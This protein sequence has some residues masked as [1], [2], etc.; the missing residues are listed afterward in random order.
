MQPRRIA[1]LLAVVAAVGLS[2]CTITFF[3][4]PSVD[5]PRP[6]PAASAVI[7]RFESFSSSYWVGSRVSFRIRTNQPGYV[8]LT[9]FDP[10]GSVY[11]IARNVAVRGNRVETIP[12]PFGRTV[13]VAV[14]PTGLH[15]VRAHFTPEPTPERIRF[16]GIGS[17]D[18]WLAQIVLEI[19]A[20]GYDAEDVAETRF[21]IRR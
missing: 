14:P 1:I 19:R 13:F 16:V 7:E 12:A 4:D 11:V 3:P 9:A 2:A 20:F 6:A 21:Q 10:D 18:A 17:V 15:L 5:R 8:T